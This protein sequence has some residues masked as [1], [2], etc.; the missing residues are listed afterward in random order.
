[1]FMEKG[2]INFIRFKNMFNSRE[3]YYERSKF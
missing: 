1:M 2:F 3:Y